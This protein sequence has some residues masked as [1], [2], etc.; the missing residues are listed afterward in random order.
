VW[1]EE[2]ISHVVYTRLAIASSQ[3]QSLK[4]NRH[5]EGAEKRYKMR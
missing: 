2:K 4:E 3:M 5:P 1:G